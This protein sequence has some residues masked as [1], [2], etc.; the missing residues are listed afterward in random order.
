MLAKIISWLLISSPLFFLAQV[1]QFSD[2]PFKSTDSIKGAYHVEKSKKFIYV[3]SKFGS[4]EVKQLNQLDSISTFFI[5][6]IVLVYSEFHKAENFNQAQL[7]LERWKNLFKTYPSFFNNRTKEPKPQ[8]MSS[9]FIS[10]FFG[11][12]GKI[13]A[14]KSCS[15]RFIFS[16]ICN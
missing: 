3:A 7:N 14:R 5:Y 16:S 1:R 8:P 6:K 12:R 4:D 9:S 15:S 11:M 10:L 2:L 13:S